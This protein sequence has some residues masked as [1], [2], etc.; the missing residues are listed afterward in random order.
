MAGAA[1]VRRTRLEAVI[2]ALIGLLDE[3]DGDPD[4]EPEPVEVDS[5]FEPSMG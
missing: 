4:L 1:S 2:E 5:D 3:I